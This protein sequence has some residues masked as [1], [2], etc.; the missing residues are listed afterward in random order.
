M[1]AYVDLLKRRRD[2]R[3]LWMGETLSL[4][5]DWLTYVAISVL[6][7]Q[8]GPGAG[9][10]AVAMVLAAH[11]LPHVLLS[12]VAGDLADRFDR[13][14]LLVG[15]HLVQAALTVAMMF[16]TS[17][18]W[19]LQGVLA[20]RSAL[21]AL[22]YPARNGALRQVVP[23]RDLLLANALSGA[24]WSVTFAV[25][26]ALGGVLAAVGPAFALGV[27]A[28]TFVAAAAL[29]AGLPALPPRADGAAGA[30]PWSEVVRALAGKPD[31]ARA[32]LA[33]TPLDVAAGGAWVLLNLRADT[34]TFVGTTALTLGVLQAVRGVGTGVGPIAA[35]RVVRTG[36][37]LSTVW[38]W[39][40]AMGLAGMALFA[41]SSA[42]AV[43]LAGALVWG[44]GVGGNWVIST[45]ELQRQ[46]ASDTVGRLSAVD[47]LATT[48]GMG[49]AALA[50]ALVIEATGDPALGAWLTLGAGATLWAVLTRMTAVQ[51]AP[52]RLAA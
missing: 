50:A 13:R 46:A 31:L 9:A 48:L 52:A 43:L 6:A 16:T 36:T 29:L 21:T 11:Q 19:V 40:S 18:I 37:P 15:L 26:M 10:L 2:Y 7:L 30:P 39:V 49:G 14:R 1:T 47:A 20:V 42:P 24:T 38:T 27:D 44:V 23:E 25:G 34:V 51:R 33:K 3:R 22:D 41:V 17:S 32:V 35:A 5:G 28:L 8:E 12:P 4:V 45:A